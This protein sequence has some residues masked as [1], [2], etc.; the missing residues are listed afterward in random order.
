M[1]IMVNLRR[2]SKMHTKKTA[3]K[4]ISYHKVS[5]RKGKVYP[6]ITSKRGKIFPKITSKR[7]K[8]FPKKTSRI[9]VKQTST[10]KKFFGRVILPFVV[11]GGV[12]GVISYMSPLLI[13]PAYSIL[14]PETIPL[15]G[16]SSPAEPLSVAV[17]NG[18][19]YGGAAMILVLMINALRRK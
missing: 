14:T 15:V 17:L 8:I 19:I 6:K 3:S 5:S 4:N 11:V 2:K 13:P 7:G 1:K 16:P 18:V 10:F 9:G 12:I